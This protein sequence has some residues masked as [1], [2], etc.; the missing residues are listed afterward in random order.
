MRIDP[1]LRRR[2][3]RATVGLLE[4]A[5][6]PDHTLEHALPMLD[7]ISNSGL[8]EAGRARLLE[9]PLLLA[10]ARERYRG[11]WPDADA[12][13]AMP[14]GSLGRLHQERLQRLGLQPTPAPQLTSLE[15][16]GAYLLQRLRSTHD[17]HH[18]VLGL[19]ITLAGE[20]AGATYYA[21]ALH[22]PGSVAILAAWILHGQQESADHGAIWAGIRFGLE[23]AETLGHRLLAMRWEE[24]WQ[25]P[26]SLWRQRLGLAELLA[27]SPF[28]EELALL[29]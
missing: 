20:A 10:L 5:R 2:A 17:L 23:L 25:E 12:L 15:G 14:T 9:D 29:S 8:G 1:Q 27:R 16:D 26:I 18:A 4:T 7:V 6:D 11:P 3:L 19:P 21:Q 22:Q 13:A 24:G 28:Q